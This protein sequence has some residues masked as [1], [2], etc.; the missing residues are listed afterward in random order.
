MEETN[1]F[2]LII[3]LSQ[4]NPNALADLLEEL[5][6][7]LREVTDRKQNEKV[8][9]RKRR[10]L[11][12]VQIGRLFKFISDRGIFAQCPAV[13]LD[14]RDSNALGS[15]LNE[16]IDGIRLYLESEAEK[17]K[18]SDSGWSSS[19]NNSSATGGHG[20]GG[21]MIDIKLS[22]CHF[23][24]SLIKSFPIE[25]RGS[26]LSRDLRQNLFI[27]FASWNGKYGQMFL[28][29]QTYHQL[30]S[31]ASMTTTSNSIGLNPLDFVG[32]T[33]LEFW[34]IK[35]MSTVL[36]AGSL[37]DQKNLLDGSSLYYWLISLLNAADLRIQEIGL[38]T[39]I[40]LLENNL[41]AGKEILF[42]I[43]LV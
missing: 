37:F 4:V 23:I 25:Q 21:Y 8:R 11:L 31:S 29:P 24:C 35:S 15:V 38:D 6:P 34:S 32:L 30:L 26:K 13:V 27:L 36:C 16:Y 17:E 1:N 28:R 3:G 12:R 22:Y 7:Y 10:E 9:S 43:N 20:H 5:N 39:L 33:E 40:L 18:V 2:V 14:C 42:L 19:S 41:D